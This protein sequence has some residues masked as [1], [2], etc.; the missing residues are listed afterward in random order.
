MV[1]FF[2]IFLSYSKG[3][4][5]FNKILALSFLNY[6]NRFRLDCFGEKLVY[7]VTRQV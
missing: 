7:C 4:W 6:E 2:V 1:E 5:N 3:D